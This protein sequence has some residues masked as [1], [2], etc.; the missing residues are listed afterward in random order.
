MEEAQGVAVD[1]GRVVRV[2]DG[3]EDGDGVTDDVMVTLGEAPEE[4]V[5]GG[6]TVALPVPDVQGVGVWQGAA[7]L[8][9][10]RRVPLSVK[11]GLAVPLVVGL[12]LVLP[13]TVVVANALLGVANADALR[14]GD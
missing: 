10:M 1:E 6:F 12:E 8:L 5:R 7:L 4:T 3:D 11:V 9:G 14:N 13:Q 2:R